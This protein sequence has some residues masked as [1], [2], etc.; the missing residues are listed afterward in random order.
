MQN[1]E[2]RIST[3]TAVG[4]AVAAIFILLI[5][6]F[7]AQLIAIESGSVMVLFM[8]KKKMSKFK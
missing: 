2:K 1:I 7:M 8:I 4:G 5:S 6:Q 3:K